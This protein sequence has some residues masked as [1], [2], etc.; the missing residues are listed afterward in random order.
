MP[1]FPNRSPRDFSQ[2]DAMD[3]DQL[4]NILREDA[5]KPEGEE[6]DIEMLLYVMEVLAKRRN[7][8]NEA[9][10]PEATLASFR[11]NYYTGEISLVS[12]SAPKKHGGRSHWRKGLVAAAAVLALVVGS[13]VTAKAF[14]CDFW[15]TIV[16]WTQETFHFGQTDDSRNPEREDNTPYA[17]LQ[18]ALDKLNIHV[19]LVPAWIP[20]G[21]VESTVKI[22]ETPKQ[23]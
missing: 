12:G 15:E 23:G 14:G 3:D 10:D 7:E 16:K 6:S 17:G 4:Q 20:E 18:D 8:R 2:Y 5:S 19:A 11:K 13:S 22:Y 1:N 9:K 21:Y